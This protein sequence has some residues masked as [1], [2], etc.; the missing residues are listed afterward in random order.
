MEE[1]LHYEA[2]DSICW[3]KE[4]PFHTTVQF[5]E[6]R[7]VVSKLSGTDAHGLAQNRPHL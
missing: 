3:G 7:I 6:D 1:R 4:H 2:N 5:L